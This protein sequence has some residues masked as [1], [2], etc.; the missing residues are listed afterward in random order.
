MK[1]FS[2][3]KVF[4][5]C[6]LCSFCTGI[7]AQSLDQAKKLY[8][9]GE[10]AEAK[11]AFER[12]VKQAPNNG[13]YNHW[14]GV[15]CYETGDM[16]GAEKHLKVGVSRKVQESYRYLAEVYYETYRFEEASELFDEYIAL[17]TKKK[18]DVEPFQKRK[19]LA[20]NAQRLLD[21]VEDVQVI[22][23]M[24]V[25]KEDFLKAY[26]LSEESG[27]L[28]SFQDFFQSALAQ[29]STVFMNQK[30]D[31]IY[32]AQETPDNGL[33]L[34]TQSRLMDHWGD[35]KQLPLNINSEGDNNY[36]FVL[37]DGIT[38]YYA[39]NGS[40][41]LGGYDLYV[42]RY[43]SSSDTYLTPE[44]LGMPYNS[45]YND[46]MIVFDDVKKLGWFVSDR[47]QPEDKV[48]VYLFIP[49]ET[50]ARVENEDIE[51][52]RAKA[53]LT[54]IDATWKEGADYTAQIKLAHE[55]IPFGKEEIKKDF[56]FVINN[57]VVYYTLE[58]ITS[59]EARSHYEKV[60]NFNKQIAELNA[61]L[62]E[63]R[64][65]YSEGNSAK[66]SQLKPQILQA[67]S[68]LDNLLS[69]P[70]EWEKKARNAEITYL[71]KNNKKR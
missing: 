65:A 5:I 62:S 70:K 35:E 15:C 39:S 54:S 63:M 41:S 10:Y 22:D 58:D 32:Y 56:E 4:F 29:Q 47:F 50:R 55:E 45:P 69:Q 24:V 25:N 13:S 37:T 71:S 57:T 49:N 46:Y 20:D 64:M 12:L 60:V 11:P 26:A 18:Q 52:K 1:R 19:D 8:N 48:C 2:I 23:S 17:L 53:S 59:P 43:N 33:S 28:S 16:E 7:Q 44:Q 67:E 42:T 61:K 51:V 9:E 6:C 38:L 40:G 14:Y 34:F 30:G 66:K 36:P 27:T 21:K 31:K 3:I 68:Q